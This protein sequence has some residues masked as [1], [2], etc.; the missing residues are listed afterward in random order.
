MLLDRNLT[1]SP[2]CD[3]V[4]EEENFLSQ[5]RLPASY[6]PGPGSPVRLP[7]AA[8]AADR[9]GRRHLRQPLQLPPLLS[10]QPQVLCRGDEGAP[11]FTNLLSK[12][13]AELFQNVAPAPHHTLQ[14][15]VPK[16]TFCYFKIKEDMNG[17]LFFLLSRSPASFTGCSSSPSMSFSDPGSALTSF[18]TP[19]DALTVL[20][21]LPFPSHPALLSVSSTSSITFTASCMFSHTLSEMP[22]LIQN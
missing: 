14:R 3:R 13:L 15:P 10:P 21:C 12:T 5:D 16:F 19:G 17:N 18:S 4:I 1:L 9:A 20:R 11:L 8:P 6:T 2:R 7:Q 22:G